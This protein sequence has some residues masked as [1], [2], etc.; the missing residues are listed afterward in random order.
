[1]YLVSYIS[2]FNCFENF[3]NYLKKFIFLWFSSK[4]C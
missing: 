4:Y 1:M 2:N 3:Y